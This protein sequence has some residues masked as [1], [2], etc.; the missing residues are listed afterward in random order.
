M[1]SKFITV[2]RIL[3]ISIILFVLSYLLVTTKAV[4]SSYHFEL[5]SFIGNIYESKDDGYFYIRKDS[6]QIHDDS[7]IIRVDYEF[8]LGIFIFKIDDVDHVLLALSEAK[9]FY[10]NKNLVYLLR[11]IK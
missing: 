1:K 8:N 9:I 2:L 5:D 4:F 6:L 3:L 11:S 10:Q 7:L